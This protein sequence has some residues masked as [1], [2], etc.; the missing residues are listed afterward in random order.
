MSRA[1]LSIKILK[2]VFRG[3]GGE[4]LLRL[5]EAEYSKEV[6]G[7]Q[8][9]LESLGNQLTQTCS[10]IVKAG[11][12]SVEDLKDQ[13]RTI[14]FESFEKN[15][16]LLQER[17]DESQERLNRCSL[18][19]NWIS[20]SQSPIIESNDRETFWADKGYKVFP[21]HHFDIPGLESSRVDFFTV[22]KNS[23]RAYCIFLELNRDAPETSVL[24]LYYYLKNSRALWDFEEL[25]ILQIFSPNYVVDKK[26]KSLA[27]A[28][29]MALFLGNEMSG[30]SVFGEKKVKVRYESNVFG[31]GQ[32]D[33]FSS[34]WNMM[35]D[36][37][38]EE[39]RYELLREKLSSNP[40]F[41]ELCTRH[42]N[43]QN[44]LSLKSTAAILTLSSG[45]GSSADVHQ[46]VRDWV[47]EIITFIKQTFEDLEK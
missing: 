6:E 9:I 30:V 23:K 4:E 31:V 12:N 13:I 29:E 33:I 45:K 5:Q 7:A 35:S 22:S 41:I 18:Q 20:G 24:K 34:F 15:R 28:R 8:A 19:K 32:Y 44:A 16:E 1:N 38:D 3:M 10:E 47:L 27:L 39:N 46:I 37:K 14:N 40:K 43:R 17:I 2:E 25:T 36:D 21:N 11:I 26:G 42:V